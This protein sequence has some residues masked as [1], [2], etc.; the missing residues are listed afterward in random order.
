MRAFTCRTI[1]T[2]GTVTS[3]LAGPD[4]AQANGGH[5]HFGTLDIP[6]VVFY[7][8][9]GFVALVVLFFFANWFR[10]RRSQS[11][12]DLSQRSEKSRREEEKE[13]VT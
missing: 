5:V 3:A 2:L 7:C 12:G 1:A 11:R 9:G 13:D 4:A 10:Y 8:V 6:L